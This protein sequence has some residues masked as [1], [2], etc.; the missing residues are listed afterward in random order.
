RWLCNL[1]L[2]AMFR[3]LGGNHAIAQQ[4]L[5]AL[6]RP[7]FDE[8]I[9]LYD[10]HFANQLR[11]VNEDY[12]FRPD[13]IMRDRAILLH[14]MFKEIDGILRMELTKRIPDKVVREP[15]RKAVFAAGPYRTR[16]R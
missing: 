10:Q 2:L 3:S 4:H 15:G 12:V 8:V 14:Q 11:I 5:A 7:L 9:V 16:N 1:A 13:T 6:H